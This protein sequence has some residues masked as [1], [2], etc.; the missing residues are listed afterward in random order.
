MSKRKKGKVSAYNEMNLAGKER[1]QR[2]RVR[3]PAMRCP[4]CETAVQP[5]DMRNHREKHCP[6]KQEP[7][8]L[9]TWVDWD[10]V[11]E[12]GIPR[13]SLYLFIAQGRIRIKCDNN[14]KMALLRDLEV[15]AAKRKRKKE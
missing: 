8:H 7:H 10:E 11:L 6:G 5:I 13:S 14:V 1:F 2:E 12:Y 15:I 4:I 9:A 3:E